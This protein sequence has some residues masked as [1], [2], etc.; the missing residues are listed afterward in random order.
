MSPKFKKMCEIYL[1]FAQDWK[2]CCDFSL[3]SKEEL[4]QHETY[5]KEIS[6][7]NGFYVGKKYLNLSVNMWREDI[8]YGFLSK[9]ELF[10]D[11]KFPSWWLNKV[12]SSV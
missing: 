2:D 4:F 8:K 12:L 6:S 1:I 5:G 3:E 9:K 11:G 10:Q 7:N